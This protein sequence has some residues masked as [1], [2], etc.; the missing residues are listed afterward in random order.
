MKSLMN[1]HTLL[2]LLLMPCVAQAME[3]TCKITKN[4]NDELVS[5]TRTRYWKTGCYTE[6]AVYYKQSGV[7]KVF[8]HLNR[9]EVE[10]DGIPSYVFD[11]LSKEYAE[12]QEEKK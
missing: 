4:E 12:K 5:Y 7:H 1:K 8:A 2:G 9:D 10:T 6:I 3:S 11:T